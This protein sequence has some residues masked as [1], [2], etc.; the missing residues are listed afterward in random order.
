[1][2]IES[3]IN[4]ITV[5]IKLL[6]IPFNI[7]PDTPQALKAALDYYMNIIFNNLDFISFFVNV[8]TLKTVA[9]VAIAI[10]TLDKAY[11]LLIWIIHKL[12]LSIN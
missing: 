2:I 5:V 4:L 3:L 1:M 7:L 8:D 12:P 6:A 11:N 9:L 10:W